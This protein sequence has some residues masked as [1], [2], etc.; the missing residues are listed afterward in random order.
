MFGLALSELN[1]RESA[2]ENE[3]D[4]NNTFVMTQ[5]QTQQDSLLSVQTRQDSLIT[6]QIQ[7]KEDRLA[8]VSEENAGLESR[9]AQEILLQAQLK[10]QMKEQLKLN[11]ELNRQAKRRKKIERKLEKQYSSQ[12]KLDGKLHT[13]TQPANPDTTVSQTAAPQLQFSNPDGHGLLPSQIAALNQIRD[14]L[15]PTD[16]GSLIISGNLIVGNN[17]VIVLTDNK[18]NLDEILSAIQ[19]TKDLQST[20][21][22]DITVRTPGNA[23]KGKASGMD[24]GK[25]F[26]APV[27][28]REYEDNQIG[29]VKKAFTESLFDHAS[30][31][32]KASTMGIGLELSTTLSRNLQLRLGYDYAD[33]DWNINLKTKDRNLQTAVGI[34]DFPMLKTNADFSYRNGHALMDLYPVR[35]GI[36]HFTAG[37]YYGESKIDIDGQVVHPNT[38]R[39]LPLAKDQT[40]PDLTF[41]NYAVAVDKG[42]VKSEMILGNRWKPYF[43]IGLGRS[44]PK[45][46]FGLK[47][48]AGVLYQGDF[49]MKQNGKVPV[50]DKTRTDSFIDET[51]YTKWMNLYPMVSLQLIYRIW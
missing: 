49:V 14:A 18:T 8:K 41:A 7:Q 40:W 51:S 12:A 37:V 2:I 3:L 19:C 22:R 16:D 35:K 30:L 21:Y 29:K 42:K 39:P 15:T 34:S 48:E 38:K 36:F 13:A 10:A 44:V 46:R 5:A 9:K 4:V 24:D 45:T 31:G 11:K 28:E 17:N 25:D 23:A 1:A 26:Y 47:I 6:T 33:K 27:Y 32:V 43:G 50:R 20:P